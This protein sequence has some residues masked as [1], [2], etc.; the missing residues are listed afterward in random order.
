MRYCDFVMQSSCQLCQFDFFKKN[1]N[2]KSVFEDK[3]QNVSGLVFGNTV[4]FA[5][6]KKK[7]GSE[8]PKCFSLKAFD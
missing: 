4:L 7:G 8:C 3:I 2:S 5:L 1:L 6:S